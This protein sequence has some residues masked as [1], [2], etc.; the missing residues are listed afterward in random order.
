MIRS[1]IRTN[2]Q[3]K[4]RRIVGEPSYTAI[5]NPIAGQD[6]PTK[7][8]AEASLLLRLGRLVHYDSRPSFVK[9]PQ[10]FL[11]VSYRGDWDAWTYGFLG[12]PGC[13]DRLDLV[14]GYDSREE[15]E[16][17]GRSHAAQA[18]WPHVE[19]NGAPVIEN[20]RDQREFE[21]WTRFQRDYQR[22]RAEG[23]TDDE[24]HVLAHGRA[25]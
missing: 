9:L 15:A 17:K 18:L 14:Q 8:S 13:S 5:I 3:R 16:R 11:V 4:G 21:F 24:A 7:A 1:H 23:K 20:E 10:G 22:L 2:R 25:R 6:M 19:D 12:V